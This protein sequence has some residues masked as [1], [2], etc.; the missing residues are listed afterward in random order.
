MSIQDFWS[1]LRFA[2]AILIAP[3]APGLLFGILDLVLSSSPVGL[4][5]YLRFSAKA[6]YPLILTVGVLLYWLFALNTPSKFWPTVLIGLTLGA[7]A[8]VLAFA[9]GLLSGDASARQGFMASLALL[10]VS[11]FCGALAGVTFWLIAPKV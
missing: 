1:A 5:W 7:L 4:A 3:L 10:P 9:P 6:G 2:I 8:Y 11:I